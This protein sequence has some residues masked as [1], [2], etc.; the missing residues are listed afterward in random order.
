MLNLCLCGI[1]W[2]VIKLLVWFKFL[3]FCMN[4]VFDRLSHGLIVSFEYMFLAKKEKKD[5]FDR[6]NKYQ[7]LWSKFKLEEGICEKE[8]KK[9]EQVVI[10]IPTKTMTTGF[11]LHTLFLFLSLLFCFPGW[12][13]TPCF[14]FG[15]LNRKFVGFWFCKRIERCVNVSWAQKHATFRPN[16][17]ISSLLTISVS[18][19]RSP[20][21][22]SHATWATIIIFFLVK[23]RYPTSFS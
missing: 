15:G 23:L 19:W 1:K 12:S 6:L 7:R 20:L 16:P 8:A 5:R 13:L 4:W 10:P 3:Y 2:G 9:K 14:F 22:L 17:L 11:L 18:L 21:P